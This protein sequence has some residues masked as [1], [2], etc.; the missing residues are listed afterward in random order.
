MLCHVKAPT[1]C[2][3]FCVK[4]MSWLTSNTYA[5]KATLHG[6]I[7]EKVAKFSYFQDGLNSGGGVQEV[8]T[9]RIRCAWKK[10]KDIASILCKRAVSL[11]LRESTCKSC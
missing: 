6:D 2:S 11:K 5:D 8:A 1:Q 7:I 3:G 10:F 9:A 4:K